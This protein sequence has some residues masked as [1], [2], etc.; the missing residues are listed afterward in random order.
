MSGKP[1]SGEM[2]EI[3]FT[4][5]LVGQLERPPGDGL[6]LLWL[7]QAGFVIDIAGLRVVIDPYLSDSLA[8]KYRGTRYP[9]VRMMPPPITPDTL[10][11]VDFV[12]CTHAHTDHMD[13]GTLPALLAANSKALLVGPRAVREAA[14]QRSGVPES[15]LCLVD[16]GEQLALS[17][18]VKLTAT[19]AAHET[20]ERDE[21]GHHRFLGYYI[22]APSKAGD[23]IALWHSGDCVP[24]DGLVAEV[25][26]LRPDIALLPVNGRKPELSARGVPG[27][28]S[29]SEA[30]E[31]TQG[32]G[33]GEMVAHHYGLFDF[34]TVDPGLIDAWPTKA[35]QPRVVRAREAIAF[36][37][38]AN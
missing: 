31:I 12:L 23:H 15:R 7:G 5:A 1:M 27:N 2:K 21:A 28:F 20:L 34:N 29:L 3:P 35:D 13:P 8:E 33:A 18:R 30:V 19:R 9:H 37:W 24:F 25:A 16:A 10:T 14:L 32:I 22:E 26:A 17:D 38:A 11:G 36:E 4:G 6:R